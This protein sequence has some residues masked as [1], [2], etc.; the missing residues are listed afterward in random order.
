M[1]NTRARLDRLAKLWSADE[2]TIGHLAAQLDVY[3]RFPGDGPPAARL[4]GWRR[5]VARYGLPPAAEAEALRRA[6]VRLGVAPAVAR[7]ATAGGIGPLLAA[8]AG[9][10][11]G[12]EE[13]R[14]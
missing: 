12:D 8:V 14:R 9:D 1:P 7:A 11:G 2:Q 5:G 4:A 10:D 13:V 3:L 6:V